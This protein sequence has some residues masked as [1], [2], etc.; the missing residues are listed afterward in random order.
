MIRTVSMYGEMEEGGG[1]VLFAGAESGGGPS[2]VVGG[3]GVLLRFEADGVA[4]GIDL[5]T[6]ADDGAI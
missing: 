3:I 2:G 5:A 1:A 6:L 4:A